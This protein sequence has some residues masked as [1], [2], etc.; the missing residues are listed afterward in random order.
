M[1]LLIE[2]K[3]LYAV[4]CLHMPE[5]ADSLA[6]FNYQR[7]IAWGPEL[8]FI[9]G[10]IYPW[11]VDGRGILSPCKDVIAVIDE[12]PTECVEF[13]YSN[14]EKA[15]NFNTLYQG[16][17]SGNSTR[18]KEDEGN[19]VAR[20]LRVTI[21]NLQCRCD[22]LRRI[23]ALRAAHRDKERARMDW[24]MRN[25]SGAVLREL[26]GEMTDTGDIVEFSA[27]IDSRMSG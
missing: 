13:V 4:S 15:E 9:A 7:I 27:L 20:E 16:W 1:D 5:Y 14:E 3:P 10:A 6:C 24:L 18:E 11:V 26:L 2:S 22:D 21:R 17:R 23:A 25:L 12:L 19:N 8:P